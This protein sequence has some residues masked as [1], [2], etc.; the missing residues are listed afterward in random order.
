MKQA[1]AM[2]PGTPVQPFIDA[3]TELVRE[4]ADTTG[5]VVLNRWVEILEQHFPPHLPDPG[6]TTE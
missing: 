6:H 1:A 5:F 3:L 2:P 4:Q